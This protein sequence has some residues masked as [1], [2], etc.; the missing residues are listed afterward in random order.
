MGF[1]NS[2]HRST[3]GAGKVGGI[4]A[5]DVVERFQSQNLD[6]R[7]PNPKPRNPNPN[8]LSPTPN[9]QSPIPNPSSIF[10]LL[11][12][13][14]GDGAWNMAVDEALLESV[15][16][17][18]RPT[19]RF[20][21]WREP[22][23]SLGY[24]QDSAE[25]AR[26]PASAECPLVRRPSGGGAIVH[27]RELTYGLALPDRHRL[28]ADRLGT[29]RAVHESLIR[30]LSDWDIE[31]SLYTCCMAAA[32]R[33]KTQNNS[34][35]P[36]ASGPEKPT[37]PDRQPFLCFQ[38]RALGDVLAGGV[39]IAGSAQRRRRGAVL[40]HGSVLLARSAAAP[41]LDGLKERTGR[42]IS[43]DNLIE[44]WLKTLAEVLGVEW[45][46]SVLAGG[47]RSRAAV[48]LGEKYASPTWTINR[49]RLQESF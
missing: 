9:P 34:R 42:Q 21:G 4:P 12:D 29:Y 20:Y 30:A 38:R 26:H 33:E 1:R 25:R 32:E 48:L 3:T 41:E 2:I 5:T 36:T 18:E 19:L 22:T 44:A 49:G 43:A 23:L 31:A 8:P 16:G 24:F 11:I 17:G 28:A 37:A 13:P 14:P 46:D 35:R 47:E 39:K 15:A 27:D 45:A 40:Q 10:R 7:I 6:S